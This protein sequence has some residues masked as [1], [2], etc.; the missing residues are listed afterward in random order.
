M[1]WSCTCPIV[2]QPERVQRATSTVFPA[3][4]C[5][6]RTT[7]RKLLRPTFCNVIRGRTLTVSGAL[8]LSSYVAWYV[9]RMRGCTWRLQ[10]PPAVVV[11]CVV[12]VGS[13]VG[14]AVIV[15]VSP[16][17]LLETVPDRVIASPKII[18]EREV[19]IETARVFC[20]TVTL[21]RNGPLLWL[22]PATVGSL[23]V[24]VPA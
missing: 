21:P 16:A 17:C 7:T 1:L 12:H 14:F 10:S 22:L 13:P 9:V 24:N 3:I 8:A 11:T 18:N 4:E 23:Y 2:V 5:C 6:A 15:T 19:A 20:A